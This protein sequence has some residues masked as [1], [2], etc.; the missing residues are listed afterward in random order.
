MIYVLFLLLFSIQSVFCVVGSGGNVFGQTH[1]NDIEDFLAG[2]PVRIDLMPCLLPYEITKK[3]F[4]GVVVGAYQCSTNNDRLSQFF[5]PY[6]DLLL[7]VAGGNDYFL[8]GPL[9]YQGDMPTNKVVRDIDAAVL[10]ISDPHF[11]SIINLELKSVTKYVGLFGYYTFMWNENCTPLM[12][13]QCAVPIVNYFHK[14]A[15]KETIYKKGDINKKSS[16]KNALDGLSRKDL[17]HQRW[18]FSP[19]GMQ[20]TLIPRVELNLSYNYIP[21]QNVSIETYIGCLLPLHDNAYIGDNNDAK[22]T[23]IFYPT[24]FSS[25]YFG[26]QY[27][28]TISLFL[29]HNDERAI[30]FILGNNLLYFLPNNEIRSFDLEGRSWSRYLYAYQ[31]LGT[32]ESTC[33]PLTN[34]LTYNCRVSPNFSNISTTE[35]HYMKDTYNIG[36]G[37]SLFARQSESVTI[38]DDLSNIVLQGTNPNI[39]A[40]GPLSIARSVALRLP[41]EDIQGIEVDSDSGKSTYNVNYYYAKINNTMI[42][43]A[44]ATHPAVFCSDLYLKGSVFFLDIINIFGGFSYRFSHN[45]TAIQYAGGWVGIECLF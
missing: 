35:L 23:F 26:F 7:T 38:L 28:T 10:D 17:L 20:V 9:P 16:I 40:P 27:G 2:G 43:I 30:K 36:L 42:D 5:L 44:S 29:Y 21:M 24:S 18:N 11:F 25:Q 6:G 45:N 13:L 4:N 8:P 1:F 31:N 39:P 3:Q 22:N 15:G 19:S 33:A 37:Y 32:Q 41:Y 14:A 12:S 34:F